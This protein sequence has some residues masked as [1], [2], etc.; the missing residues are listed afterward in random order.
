VDERARASSQV[1]LVTSVVAAVMLSLGWSAEVRAARCGSMLGDDMAKATVR[2]TM[3][4]TCPCAAANSRGDY[5]R[6]AKGVVNQAVMD[7][8]LP[9]YCASTVKKCATRST[10]G[11]PPGWVTCCR[12]TASGKTSCK[13]KSS[14]E[15][16]K[17]PSGGQ[18]CTTGFPS[19]CDAC[20]TSGC[21][22]TPTPAPPTITSTPTITPTPTITDTPTIPA[23]CQ[24]QITVTPLA[25]VP[26]AL[27]PASMQCG[28][29]TLHN[30]SP[31]PPLSGSVADGNAVNIGDLG[32]GCLYTGS[33]P[34]LML[35]SGSTSKLDVVGLSLLPSL[36]LALAGS[37]GD[38]PTNCT[39]G[40]GPGRKCA[41]GAPGLDNA[42][43]CN[44][45]DDCTGHRPT[46]C[47]LEPNCYFGPPI[48]VP[49]GNLSSCVV[50]AFQTDLCGQI[51]LASQ[52]ST[53]ATAL[54]S[55]VYLTFDENSPC[56]RCEGG[57]CNGGDRA[58]LTCTPLGSEQTSIDCPPTASTF[59]G[60]LSVVIPNLSSGVTNLT[61]S[62][63][64]FCEGQSAP[65]AF[66]LQN[67][68]SVTESGSAPSLS[69]LSLQTNLGG[70]FCIAPSGAEILDVI[71][72]LPTVGALAVS[73]D[74]DLTAVLVP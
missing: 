70:V 18:S 26:I 5:I 63:G 8:V 47:A 29:L 60:V 36:S 38:G 43:T 2:A 33:L 7:G 41:N 13:V 49:L 61:S 68:R 9:S 74:V 46:V 66:G 67:A 58:G 25:Q 40:A 10:C 19:C 28:G 32:L 39:R 44:F 62:D 54:S 1:Q 27:A 52:T 73:G 24:A 22:D 20:T 3:E 16:C 71:A 15:K 45:D 30:P 31:A 53:F 6:C 48:P 57:V 4:M 50:N 37:A 51:D 59:I 23:I 42:G 65:G 35:P 14:A 21:V 69:G 11:R 64:L 56:P 34:P 12:T 55:R 17:A 72:G